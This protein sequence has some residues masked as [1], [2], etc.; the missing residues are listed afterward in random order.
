[1]ASFYRKRINLVIFNQGPMGLYRG[2]PEPLLSG[3]DQLLQGPRQTDPVSADGCRHG[4]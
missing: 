4:H 1:M 3:T 2:A